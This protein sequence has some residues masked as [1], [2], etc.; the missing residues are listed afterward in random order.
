MTA[1]VEFQRMLYTVLS[2][3]SGFDVY[4][5]APQAADGASGAPFPYVTIGAFVISEWDTQTGNGF[6]ALVRL[7]T[8]SRT[9]SNKECLEI[10]AQLYGALHKQS[11][12]ITNHSSVLMRRESTTIIHEGDGQIHGVCEYRCLFD[13]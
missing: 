10:Q 6:D 13:A 12:S 4:D 3:L 9:G 7:H 1:E 5:I 2:P 8:W 11:L